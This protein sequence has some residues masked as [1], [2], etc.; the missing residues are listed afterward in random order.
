[1]SV[2]VALEREVF[3]KFPLE[4]LTGRCFTASAELMFL[5]DLSDSFTVRI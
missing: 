3:I 2:G 4:P 1:M 5:H